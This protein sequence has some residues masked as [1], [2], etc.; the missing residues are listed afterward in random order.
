MAFEPSFDK[1][2]ASYRKNIGSTQAQIDCKLPLIEDVNKV[3]CSN[4]KAC[5]MQA[6]YN[7]KEVSYSGYVAFQVTYLTNEN[8]PLALDYTAEFKETYPYQQ[9]GGFTP[10]VGVAVVDVNT[11]VVGGEI[12]VTAIVESAIDGIFSESQN[13]LVGVNGDNVFA[14]NDILT[15]SSFVGTVQ[16]RFDENNDIEIKDSVAKVLSVCPSVYLDSV[17]VFDRYVT[18]KGGVFVD[19][20]YVAENN[21][22]RTAQG[23][24]AF[25]QEV[26]GD[27][28]GQDS[29]VQSVVQLAFNDIKI[30]TS[31]DTDMAIVNVFT[32][33]MYTGYVYNK[34][35]VD[36]VTDLFSG[37]HFTNVNVNSL[38]TMRE[39][40]ETSFDDKISG[41]V[42]IQ[43]NAPFI[44]EM[45]GVCCGNV[46]LANASINDGNFTV[47]GVAHTN[48]LYLNKELN[49]ICSVE[50]EMPFSLTNPTDYTNTVMP[51]VQLSVT[52]IN[53]RARRGKDI[54]VTATLA[55]FANFFEND[56]DAVITA[57]TEEDEVPEEECAL[58]IYLTKDGDTIW[59]IAKELRVSPERLV[60]Q[61]PT[62]TE[63]ITAGTRIVVYRQKQVEY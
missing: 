58:S 38:P 35:T 34:N 5:V 16:N 29:F 45:L 61:N 56:K 46:A 55:V 31:I 17:E 47:E 22:I 18:V 15:Y 2:T 6:D 27:E 1:I 19:I 14:K 36:I 32:P 28:I 4:A 41:N 54:E 30:T 7:G 13:V 59:D 48:V 44:D 63:P 20:S 37:T 60:E 51:I 9:E 25:T 11:Q 8:E 49:T 52:E 24:F 53:A 26:A 50:V 10:V 33:V 40:A 21:T 3:V 12:K 23:K 57:V 62:L 42:E 43:E 39:Y